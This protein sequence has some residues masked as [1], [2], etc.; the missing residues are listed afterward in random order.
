ML[1]VARLLARYPDF[2]VAPETLALCRDMAR[3]GELKALVAERVWQELAKGLLERIPSRMV[4]FLGSCGVLPLVLPELASWAAAL[5]I[6]DTPVGQSEAMRLLDVA[7]RRAETLEVCFAVL[8]Q[9]T[10]L[11]P[12][13][14]QAVATRLKLPQEC[15]DLGVAV[16]REQGRLVRACELEDLEL[17]ELFQRVDAFR[18]PAR[19]RAILQALECCLHQA[20]TPAW[21][22]CGLAQWLRQAFQAAASVNAGAIAQQC[23]SPDEIATRVQTAR[24]DAVQA[25]RETQDLREPL[26]SQ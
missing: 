9:A 23:A 18:R 22:S 13:Q 21:A 10:G 20:D 12:N 1:R 19:L 2:R 8:C 11:T 26:C 3:T 25:W 24:E 5:Q 7:A 17:V 15:R 16:C 4:D 14:V 6:A